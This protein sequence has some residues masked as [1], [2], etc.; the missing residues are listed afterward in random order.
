[1]PR[2]PGRDATRDFEDVGHSND[3]RARLDSLVIGTVRPA[4][5]AEL[6]VSLAAGE[7]ANGKGAV[8]DGPVSWLGRGN[9][10]VLK[11]VGAASAA[12]AAII[13]LAYAVQR[14]SV[15]RK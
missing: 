15:M 2:A 11:T 13:V 1:M 14:Y 9:A 8:E 7:A 10:G 12:S 5:S 6:R 4:T 3:A